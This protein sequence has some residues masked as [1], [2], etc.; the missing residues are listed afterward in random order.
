MMYRIVLA[1]MRSLKRQLKR[2]LMLFPRNI[3]LYQRNKIIDASL[4]VKEG[5]F[6]HFLRFSSQYTY[7]SQC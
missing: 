5:H 2:T 4:E 1:R 6:E 7:Y 3:K